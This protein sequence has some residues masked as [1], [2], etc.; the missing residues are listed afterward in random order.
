MKRPRP[1]GSIWLLRLVAVA[2]AV[3]TGLASAQTCTPSG[4]TVTCTGGPSTSVSNTNPDYTTTGLCPNNPICPTVAGTP[5]AIDV[6]GGGA[7][8]STVSVTVHGYTS[9]F[10]DTLA[11]PDVGSRDM[12][13]LLV[14][15]TDTA[16]S[17]PTTTT[18]TPRPSTAFTSG[19]NSTITL[20]ATVSGS[21]GT[22]TGT[23][24]FRNGP[25]NLTCSGGN[26]ATLSG[27]AAVCHTTISAQEKRI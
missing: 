25:N 14:S 16:A 1:V 4:N 26:P 12:G 17:T 5:T 23:V 3:S 11:T 27:C 7:A 15:P 6:T 22:P 8:V 2:L 20:T 13:L 9:A 21:G 10:N 18:L 24:T 19:A